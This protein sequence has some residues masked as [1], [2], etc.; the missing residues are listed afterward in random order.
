MAGVNR[1]GRLGMVNAYLVR[2]RRRP[3]A[4]RHDNRWLRGQDRR[5]GRGKRCAD[6][7]LL[8]THVHGDHVGSLDELKENL[9]QAEVII[10]TRDVRLIA[11]DMSLD[12]DEPKAKLRGGIPA[13][14]PSP[15]VPST[16][17]IGSAHSM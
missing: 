12:P 4:D 11:R 10:S 3:D 2:R 13:P 17:A 9:P 14:R 1:I 8:L 7:R 5:R 16:P 15:T 6:L